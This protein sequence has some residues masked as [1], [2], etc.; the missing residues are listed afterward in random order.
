MFSTCLRIFL[1][2][3]PCQNGASATRSRFQESSKDLRR[4]GFR[5]SKADVGLSLQ[6]KVLVLERVLQALSFL[7][8]LLAMHTS[9]H[10]VISKTLELNNP[11]LA[12]IEVY[13]GLS[14]VQI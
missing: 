10:C 11:I 12:M 1:L 7:D 14:A 2:R 5:C 6:R 9:A 8:L 4:G 3:R 13:V